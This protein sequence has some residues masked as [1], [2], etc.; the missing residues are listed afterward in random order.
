MPHTYPFFLDSLIGGMLPAAGQ[1]LETLQI[2][3]S[4]GH[5]LVYTINPNYYLAGNSMGTSF[6]TEAYEF[7]IIGVIISAFVFVKVILLFEK[8]IAKSRI[9]KYFLFYMFTII[10]LSP[11]GAILPGIYDLLKYGIIGGGILLLFNLRLI[12]KYEEN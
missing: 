2:R 11:R 6:I 1:S 5:Q 4:I 12:N 9:G 7:G 3:S 8:S 10:V